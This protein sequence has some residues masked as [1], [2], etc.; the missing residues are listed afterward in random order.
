VKVSSRTSGC[1]HT[2]DICSPI[3]VTYPASHNLLC[4]TIA[5]LHEPSPGHSVIK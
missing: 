5:V 4:F 3:Q 2:K 1:F